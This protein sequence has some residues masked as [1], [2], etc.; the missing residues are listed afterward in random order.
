VIG[1]DEIASK[2]GHQDFVTP[3]TRRT[4]QETVIP[5]VLKDRKKETVK[6]FLMSISKRLRKQV[7]VVCSE[8][9]DGFI[10]A[11]K[12]GFGKRIQIVVE[13]FH[14]AKLDGNGL[15]E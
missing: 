9:Q 8:V 10:K 6:Q 3:V 15:D 12:A 4:G 2:K 1:L 11:A 7:R 13:R 14:V 5:G